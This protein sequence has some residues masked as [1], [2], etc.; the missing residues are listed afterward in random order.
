MTTKIIFQIIDDTHRILNGHNYH[1]SR[2]GKFDAV[3]YAAHF[4]LNAAEISQQDIVTVNAAAKK[5]P[6]GDSLLVQHEITS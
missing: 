4:D 2:G 3:A 6:R 1:I 5:L